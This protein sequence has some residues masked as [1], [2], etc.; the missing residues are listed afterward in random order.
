MLQS[1]RNIAVVRIWKRKSVDPH[2]STPSCLDSLF[3][4]HNASH[5]RQ[6]EQETHI[7]EKCLE[8]DSMKDC[9]MLKL[10]LHKVGLHDCILGIQTFE[11]FDQSSILNVFS[12]QNILIYF[13]YP[14]QNKRLSM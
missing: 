5:P 9:H 10:L 3:L 11:V 12:S 2:H 7:R 1:Y 13:S 14:V 6:M 8:L 4:T